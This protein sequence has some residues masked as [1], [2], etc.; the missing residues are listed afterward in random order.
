MR[1]RSNSGR[2]EVDLRFFIVLALPFDPLSLKAP[3]GQGR[4]RWKQPIS[5]MGASALGPRPM[6]APLLICRSVGGRAVRAL[7]GPG[8]LDRLRL[9]SGKRAVTRRILRSAAAPAVSVL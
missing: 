4:S 7:L 8:G 2:R 1:S 6:P 3:R 9:W 5:A